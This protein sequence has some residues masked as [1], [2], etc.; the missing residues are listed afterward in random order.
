MRHK[1]KE[2]EQAR[3]LRAQGY[4]IREICRLV[5]AAKGTISVWVRDI[6]LTPEQLQRLDD[7]RLIGR[8]RAR[9]TVI[10]KREKRVTGYER[11]AEEEYRL[12][13]HDPEFM[14]GLGLYIGE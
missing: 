14:L 7:N 6:A 4:S 9:A 1:D 13:R 12:L 11:E 3:I 10:Q 8:E 5:P 2:Y